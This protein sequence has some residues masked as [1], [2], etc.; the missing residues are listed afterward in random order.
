VTSLTSYG[1]TMS[2]QYDSAGR[3]SRLTWPDNF[4]VTYS[5][6]TLSR[7]TAIREYGAGSGIG[8]LASFTYD[9][10]GR[11]TTLGRGNGA[12]STY[13]YD[14]LSRLNS[15]GHQLSGTSNDYSASF[16][17]SPASQ[18][19]TRTSI[20]DGIYRWT[21]SNGV[22][23]YLYNDLNQM[24]VADGAS[25]SHDLD[26]NLTGDGVTTYS[27]DGENQLRTVRGTPG[28]LDLSYDPLGRLRQTE[29]PGNS[30]TRTEF[31]YDGSDMVAEYD[32]S[33]ALTRRYVHG[34]GVDAPLVMY[35]GS[36]TTTRRWL[37]ADERGSIVAISDASGNAIA[38][39]TYDPYGVPS[40]FTGS[41]FL[42]TGQM[43]LPE[44]SLYHYKARTYAPLLGRFLQTDP[45]GYAGG[46]NLYAYAG[47]DPVNGRDP[48][49]LMGETIVIGI[50]PDLGDITRDATD[51]IKDD[52]K[53]LIRE[54]NNS[55]ILRGGGSLGGG[56]G[57]NGGGGSGYSPGSPSP[58][59][60][61]LTGNNNV[62]VIGSRNKG[63]GG[64]NISPFIN[65]NA[66]L[67]DL[68]GGNSREFSD[69]IRFNL[70]LTGKMLSVISGT[71][72][73]NDARA[74]GVTPINAIIGEAGVYLG[75]L[76]TA[77]AGGMVFTRI[78]PQ[79]AGVVVGSVL[80]A[81]VFIIYGESGVRNF[82]QNV[83]GN[84][85]D[86]TENR[87]NRVSLKIYNNINN[88]NNWRNWLGAN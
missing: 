21:G 66:E 61:S 51:D 60:A 82:G 75:G 74:S 63:K 19:T 72:S 31:L 54:N 32:N 58:L 2:Y 73:Y 45:I 12:D 41:R 64:G 46:L 28:Q 42:Y 8:V 76:G 5:Y 3:R 39:F 48:S 44:V 49:G 30:A 15:L 79:P 33:G 23:N 77:A 81:G 20:N 18:I 17:Y 1:R 43:A 26:G 71:I 84:V 14:A 70:R 40:D 27:Y 86:N 56:G 87:L 62:T 68:L 69:A 34:P 29:V 24:T 59:A 37:H 88:E 80:G 57:G 22:K 10:L 38:T 53:D 6:D 9:D 52:T 13:G 50:K 7:M 4:Y 55:D 16:T 67:I 11:L 83:I 36:G 85:I 35:V 47:G 25:I 65:I 78:L